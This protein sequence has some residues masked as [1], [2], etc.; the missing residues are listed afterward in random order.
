LITEATLISAQAGGMSNLPGIFNE[1]QIAA[2]R[3]VT[4]AVHKNGSFIF[5]QIWGM[6][7]TAYPQ[8]LAKGG[9]DLVSSSPVPVQPGGPVP[10]ELPEKEI[11]VYINN[12]VQAA[13]NAIRADFVWR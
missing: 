13:Q 3:K 8:V 7:R 4:N 2:W 11:E 10:R 1:E 12:F 5:C 9:F 6:G